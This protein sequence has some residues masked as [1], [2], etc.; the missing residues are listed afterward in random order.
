MGDSFIKKNGLLYTEDLHTIVGVD[1]SSSDFTGR[2][3]YGVHVL[4]D[5]VFADTA[6]VN[7][8]IPD[9]VK[10][11]GACAFGN[12]TSLQTVKLP[13]EIKELAP[14]LFSGC[15]S[16]KKVT[17]PNNLES[18]SEGL[19]FGCS[20]LEELPFRAGITVLPEY[21]FA[22][23]KSIKSIVFPQSVTKIGK[24]AISDCTALESVVLPD[25]IQYIEADAFENCTNLHNIRLSEDNK[26]FFKGEDGSL[27]EHTAGGDKLVI[28]VY[29]V[30][31]NKVDF[32]EENVSEEIPVSDDEDMEEDDI[33]S[34]EIG[35]SDEE[36]DL[37]GSDSIITG[38]T[39]NEE[40][41]DKELKEKIMGMEENRTDVDSI[42]AD[43]M[44]DEKKRTS[45]SSE[46]IT[47]S[48]KEAQVMSEMMDVMKDSPASA[49][50]G[51]KV[52]MEELANLSFVNESQA[53]VSDSSD[54]KTDSKT[55]ILVDAV[56][57]S[58]ILEFTPSAPAENSDLFVIA[59]STST[60][61]AGNQCFSPKL[62]AC[63]KKIAQLQDFSRVILLSG[64]PVE[65]DE[66]MHFYYPFMS[67]KHVILA[68]DAASP[69][70]LSDYG[71]TICEQSR[72]SL[73][74]ESLS[75]QRKRINIK[76]D[77]LIKLVIKDV[78]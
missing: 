72:I 19:F 22:G 32:F 29:A 36:M 45:S 37:I 63:C 28:Q 25:G 3:P 5:E 17:L 53:K 61:V 26:L 6:Y 60:D 65:N 70:M 50:D 46:Q 35:A 34:P 7:V 9:S 31:Q 62:E 55:D 40:N 74:K 51:A 23:C 4:A 76:N 8:S 21:V 2:I 69:S 47:I 1:S 64:L 14:Y 57:F 24:K 42:F 10:K 39:Q 18:F 13:S 56:K 12:C 43:I 66:F 77:T 44:N 73:D 16:L 78:K 20:A 11:I 68:C 59:E 30:K 67:K 75:E 38:N 52:T 49:N 54:S 27:Y 41:N 71:K 48:D 58:K 15:S 33:F